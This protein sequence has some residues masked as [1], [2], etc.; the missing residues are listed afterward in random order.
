MSIRKRVNTQTSSKDVTKITK[1]LQS[2]M[3]LINQCIFYQRQFI[4]IKSSETNATLRIKVENVFVIVN[5]QFDNVL[6]P[7]EIVCKGYLVYNQTCK[8]LYVKGIL[9]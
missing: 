8:K 9:Y 2:S 1:L 6:L 3:V 5:L 4:F 7:K